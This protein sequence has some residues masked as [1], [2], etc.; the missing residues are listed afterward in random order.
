MNK[1]EVAAFCIAHYGLPY[2]T[3]SVESLYNQ[4]DK[5][6]IAYTDR[7]SQ[8]YP[9]GINCPDNEEELKEAVK[10]FWDKI[11]WARGQWDHEYEHC[12]FARNMAA[13]YSWRVRF[14]TDE[15]FPD[16]AVEYYINQAEPT[17]FKEWRM[18]F[19]HFWRSFGKVC[20][21]ASHPVR[22][23]RNT[24]IGLGWLHD[25]EEKYTIFHMG[26]ALPTKYIDYKMSVSGH[27]SEWRPNWYEEKWLPNSQLDVHPVIYLPAFWN[28]ENFEK[29]KLPT[30]LKK[31]KYFNEE[32]IN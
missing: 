15:I 25:P 30:V 7:W 12:D 13:D 17:E 11:V 8:S 10:P 31:H 26:Y 9:T 32:I 19:M 20:R 22:L 1:K 5:I 28:T 4:V 24:G 2:F 27:K 16:G 23:E 18:P 29:E 6:F 14:D 3:A 21:D